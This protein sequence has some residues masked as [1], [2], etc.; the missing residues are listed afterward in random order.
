ME[1]RAPPLTRRVAIRLVRRA[2]P[3]SERDW[4]EVGRIR[5]HV[6]RGRAGCDD[7]REYRR[8]RDRGATT[9][10]G[11][12]QAA[13]DHPPGGNHAWR[14]GSSSTRSTAATLTR[15]ASSL[16]EPI[17]DHVGSRSPDRDQQV[18]ARLG[19]GVHDPPDR[20]DVGRRGTPTTAATTVGSEIDVNP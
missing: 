2:A 13:C 18:R 9:V 16:A 7:P 3:T 1:S 20:V 10:P 17:V 6:E 11:G 5:S 12:L 14:R 19:D 15:V 4:Y 8:L